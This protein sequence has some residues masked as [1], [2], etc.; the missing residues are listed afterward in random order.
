MNSSSD[1]PVALQQIKIN[2]L[3]IF[4]VVVVAKQASNISL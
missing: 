3:I 1:V 2:I 4:V